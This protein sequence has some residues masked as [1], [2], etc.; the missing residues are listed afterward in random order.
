[1]N[2]EILNKQHINFSYKEISHNIVNVNCNSSLFNSTK[3]NKSNIHA[4]NFEYSEWQ[5]T[6]VRETSITDS[7]FK[8]SDIKSI[9]CS[10]TLFKN[11][12]FDSVNF[13]D[14][15]FN[16]CT[17]EN[18]SFLGTNMSENDFSK[19]TLKNLSLDS[20]YAFLNLFENVNFLNVKIGGS[21]YFSYINNSFFDK[22]CIIDSYLL[23]YFYIINDN[24]LKDVT[25]L[26]KNENYTND[27]STASENA[28]IMYEERYMLMNIGFLQLLDNKKDLEFNIAKCI[29]YL[30]KSIENNIIVK[31]EEIQFLNYIVKKEYKNRRIS[32]YSIYQYNNLL[33]NI[34]YDTKNS[35]SDKSR[36]QINILNNFT[37]VT[38][39]DYMSNVSVPNIKKID[40]YKY[41]E[42]MLKYNN[43]PSVEMVDIINNF[44][45]NISSPAYLIKTKKGSY[46][47]WISCIP[48]V[49]PYF[50]LFIDCLGLIE[51]IILYTKEKKLKKLTTESKNNSALIEIPNGLKITISGLK[52]DLEPVITVL[53]KE[54]INVHNNYKGYTKEN[55]TKIEIVLK[56]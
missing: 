13:K 33:N 10:K 51:P 16:E 18:C 38:F 54:E 30:K 25:Y 41:A 22:K 34:K 14:C 7:T 52:Q 17:F 48:A 37:Y 46:L 27:L 49:L 50:Q 44:D 15:T 3:I 21:F 47:E 42:I 12:C 19:C 56:K 8:Y 2:N 1:M 53:N 28:R 24:F 4:C 29:V 32:P 11:I 43:K 5:G 36:E 23:G 31:S 9:Y 55:V 39:L 45:L 26:L 40:D 35:I 6:Q 20:L